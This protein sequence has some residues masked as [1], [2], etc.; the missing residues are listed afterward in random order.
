M[1]Q[2]FLVRSGSFE[3]TTALD[4][5]DAVEL[6]TKKRLRFDAVLIDQNMAIMNGSDGAIGRA[7]MRADCLNRAPAA[8]AKEPWLVSGNE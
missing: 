4:G 2:R 3:V 6:V 1:L 7:V 8:G 5:A